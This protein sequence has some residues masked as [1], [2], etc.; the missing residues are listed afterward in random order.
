MRTLKREPPAPRTNRRPVA[1][2]DASGF[3]AP[4]SF[5][6]LGHFAASRERQTSNFR[7]VASIMI[8]PGPGTTGGYN[9]LPATFGP[10]YLAL[11]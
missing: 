11:G 9:L 7:G 10:A 4:G 3:R 1:W 5:G 6:I 8:L 2:G